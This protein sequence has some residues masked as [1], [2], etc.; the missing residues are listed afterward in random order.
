MEVGAEKPVKVLM[1]TS[2]L[3]PNLC[4]LILSK[5]QIYNLIEFEITLII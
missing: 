2:A 1:V 4:L 5:L 3:V